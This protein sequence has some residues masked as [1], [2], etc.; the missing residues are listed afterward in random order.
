MVSCALSKTSN[1]SSRMKFW[2]RHGR[3]IVSGMG[4]RL[5]APCAWQPCMNT[6][7]MCDSMHASTDEHHS[8]T[9]SSPLRL[10]HL[11][12]LDGQH[13]VGMRYLQQL[14]RHLTCTEMIAAKAKG[15]DC[16]VAQSCSEWMV[17]LL[18]AGATL[19]RGVRLTALHHH[20]QHLSSG[21]V[22]QHAQRRSF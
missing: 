14:A 7:H 13:A 2:L 21:T 19:S 1:A 17:S 16:R 20:Y 3:G 15:S 9:P 8:T 5:G 12:R 22:G 18:W 11:L 6:H 10:V 4:Q